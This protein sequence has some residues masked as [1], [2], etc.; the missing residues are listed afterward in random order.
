MVQLQEK[1]TLSNNPSFSEPKIIWELLPQDYILPDEPVE[2]ILQPL[3]AGA[4]TE[5]LELAGLITANMMIATNMALTTK[6]DSQTVVKHQIG[7]SYLKLC[8]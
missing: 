8:P 7:F 2:S 4:L 5:A 6:I 3:L 1:K